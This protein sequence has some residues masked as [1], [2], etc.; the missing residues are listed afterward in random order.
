MAD[1]RIITRQF[2][3]LLPVQII[4]VAISS[5][6]S[7]IDGAVAGKFIGAVALSII[8]LYYPMMKL[9]DTL[10]AV[11][12]GGSQILCGQSLGRGEL[13]KTKRIFTL[14]I[15]VTVM[16]SVL[17][18]IM[19]AAAPGLIASGLGADEQ[20][21]EGLS[22]YLR[23]M[24]FGLTGQLLASQLSSFLQ[25]EQQEKRTYI[26][27]AAMAVSNVSLNLLFVRV[28]DMG[29]FGLGLSTSL[30]SWLFCVIQASYYFTKKAAIRFDIKSLDFSFLKDMLRIGIPGAVVQLCLTFRGMALNIM[31]LHYAGNNALA[32]YSAVATFGCVYFAATAGVASATRLLVSVYYGE[33]DRAGLLIIM[34]T[35]IFK[36]VGLVSAV[37]AVSI[38]LAGVFT[39]LFCSDKSSEVYSMTLEYFRLFPLSMPLS[40]FF[41]IFSNYYQCT[42][43]MKIVNVSSVLDG[44]VGI[45]VSCLILAPIFGATGIWVSQ[46]TGGLFPTAAIFIYTVMNLKRMPRSIEDMLIIKESFGVSE[47]DRMDITVN[48]RDDVINTSE[49]VVDFCTAHGMDHKRAMCSGL[50]IEEMAGNIVDH[51]FTSGK[52]GSIDIRAVYK[53]DKLLIRFKDTCKPFDPKEYSE[54]FSPEDVTHNIG[55]R[56][57]S[58]ISSSMEYHYV[59]GLNVLSITV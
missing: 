41:V 58:R 10:N 25:L 24:S 26:G 31:I 8:G 55:I 59:L 11:L 43:H 27:I 49:A 19:F 30:S 12:V 50:C 4:L 18:G 34:K 13:D 7:I 40:C 5:V 39:G 9:M 32:A 47:Q 38:A 42:D 23:A 28:L 20:T 35:A 29:M 53:D 1:S 54:L 21:R 51:G 57:I 37:A 3:R 14:D 16:L 15:F 52:K 17:V 33:E 2:F 44:F 48:S 56:M 22:S 6:N 46:I 36:G 45:V